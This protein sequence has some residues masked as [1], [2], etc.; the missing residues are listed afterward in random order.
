MRKIFLPSMILVFWLTA[1][2]FNVDVLTPA[3]E[4]SATLPS[5]K[6]AASP[7]T[8]LATPTEVPPVGFTPVGSNPVFYA[9]SVSL[10]QSGVP[11]R[12]AFPTGTK[13]I[14]AVWH[15]QNMRAGLTI[16]REWYLNGQP[17]LFREDPW[18]FQK[19]GADGMMPDISIYD[20]EVG[21]PEGLYELRVYIDSVIQPIGGNTASGPQTF[22]IFEILRDEF[23]TDVTSPDKQ[24]SAG[25]SFGNRLVIRDATGAPINE[26]FVG[27]EIPYI[28]WLADSRH[29][30]FVDR[31]RSQGQP[32]TLIGVRDDLWIADIQTRDLHLLY[33]NNSAFHGHAGPT[34]SP[35]EKYIVSLVG[36]GYGDA[37]FVD[38]GLIFLELASDR[39]SVKVIRQEQFTGIPTSNDG[40]V[41]PLDDGGWDADSLYHVTLNGTCS[42]DQ[43]KMG[44]Y[45]FN[46]SNLTVEKSAS[47]TTQLIAGDLGWGTIHG[48]IV[49][50]VTGSPIVGA[51]VTCAHASYTSPAPCSGTATTNAQGLYVFGNVF[52][53][54]TDT[55]RL[56]VQAGGYQPKEMSQASFTFNDMEANISL[57]PVP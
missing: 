35:Y 3:P 13:Q 41:Y 24:W 5:T 8:A 46:L 39:Q 21:L 33:E 4:Q 12:I 32:G 16:K 57:T 43:S 47:S 11:A 26:I 30:L 20:F 17:W 29:L 27:S 37:C 44:R 2:S 56:T 52:F 34:L 22:L 19:Y 23:T 51:V 25:V 31:D 48:K 55:V 10:E 15:Y 14:F 38:S 9:A 1:C 45:V 28:S 7:T 40:V 18:D 36:S 49:N 50:A 42:V 53:H 54:D 6:V